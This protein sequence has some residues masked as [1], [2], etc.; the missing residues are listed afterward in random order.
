MIKLF[1][2][3][4]RN[5]LGDIED[6]FQSFIEDEFG[7]DVLCYECEE[8]K[9]HVK[10]PIKY[11]TDSIK[12]YKWTNVVYRYIPSKDTNWARANSEVYQDGNGYHVEVP[13]VF[14]RYSHRR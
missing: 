4:S 13:S 6:V 10:T 9:I 11:R 14:F 7:L 12:K 1:E 5:R 2:E 3:Y 8:S